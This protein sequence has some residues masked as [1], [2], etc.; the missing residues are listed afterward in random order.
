[1]LDMWYESMEED[2]QI[3]VTG[4]YTDFSKAFDK[5]TIQTN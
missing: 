4:I 5:L 2:G 1:M 3:D